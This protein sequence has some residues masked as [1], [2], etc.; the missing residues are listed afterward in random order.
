MDFSQERSHNSF[1]CG[2]LEHTS[3]HRE[4]GSCLPASLP[5]SSQRE[6][7]GVGLWSP[8]LVADGV[9]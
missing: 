1:R 4:L 5:V 9:T 3:V 8:R 2:W 7:A 6:G